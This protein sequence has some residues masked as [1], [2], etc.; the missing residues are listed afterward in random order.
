MASETLFKVTYGMYIVSSRKGDTLNGLVINT[1]NQVTS[2]PPCI[3][4]FISKEN[5]THD[6]ILGS[7]VF[8]ISILRQDTPLKFIGKWGFRSGKDI[9]KFQD[10]KYKIGV[11]GAPIVLDNA[12]GYM[13][14]KLLDHFSVGTHTI[15]I[16]QVMESEIIDDVE[17]L[18]YSY[19]RDIKGGRSSKNAPTYDGWGDKISNG[20]KEA[21]ARY[22]CRKCGHVYDP[23]IGDKNSGVKP[24]TPFNEIS[25][26][27]VCPLCK[28]KKEEFGLLE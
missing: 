6:Y 2:S 17:P 28:A 15:F 7:G 25:D 3:S 24:G 23:R 11:T 21:P 9:D 20:L 12:L 4:V 26:D 19:Y 8:S 22:V 1:A 10:T 16:G 5:L 13:D 27:W 14:M 18:T